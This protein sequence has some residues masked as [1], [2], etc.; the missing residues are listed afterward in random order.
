VA[1]CLASYE[2]CKSFLLCSWYHG[3]LL[4][5]IAEQRHPGLLKSPAQERLQGA[6]L[7]SQRERKHGKQAAEVE[8][9]EAETC[10]GA[11]PGAAFWRVAVVLHQSGVGD[12]Y[13]PAGP[14]GRK[15]QAAR[16]SGRSK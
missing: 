4:P 1:Y 3:V 14:A 2:W 16:G 11:V 15:F 7:W 5:S 13:A 6:S 9:R 8:G 10:P 12:V